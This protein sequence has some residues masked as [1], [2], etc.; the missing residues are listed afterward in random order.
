M[1][2]SDTLYSLRDP[3]LI[4][5][6]LPLSACFYP[7]GFP[8][9]IETDSPA[10][11]RAAEES[12]R[13]F[14]R[15][16]DVAPLRLRLGVEKAGGEPPPAAPS[17]RA[18]R[19][20][21]AIVADARNFAVC[22]YSTG[23]AFGWLTAAAVE[24][25]AWLRWYFL[26]AIVYTLLC[27]LHV[28]PAHAACAAR[29]GRGVLLCGPAGAGKSTLAYACARRG[30]KF[31]SDD[32]VAVRRG[33]ERS[34]L[35]KPYSIRFRDTASAILP[36]LSERLAARAVNGK[37]TIEIQTAELGLEPE[38]QCRADAIVFLNRS[39]AREP[40]LTPI[41]HRTAFERLARDIPM[42]D[43]PVIEEQLRSLDRLCE[44]PAFEL[45]YEALD[46]AVNQLESLLDGL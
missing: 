30:W 1:N 31:V 44:T 22:D 2:L 32:S 12:W 29:D 45:H 13:L 33:A 14:L 41:E 3:M 4:R 8:L 9:Q 24:D 37:L 25:R 27:H 18:Q 7:L 19:N 43:P 36:E 11:L 34:V 21:I 42:W 15:I 26:E 39:G 46:P 17:Y 40:S 10:V 23:F 38:L 16:F 20:L 35:G 6:E 5:A 28:T